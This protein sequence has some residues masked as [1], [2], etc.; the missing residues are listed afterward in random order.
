MLGIVIAVTAPGMARA[1]DYLLPDGP[2][3]TVV[4]G[5]CESCHGIETVSKH[6]RSPKQWDDVVQQMIQRGVAVS[7]EQKQLMLVYLKTHYGQDQDYVPQPLPFSGHGPGLALALEAA[8]TS[9]ETCKARGLK[10][11]TLVVDSI[12]NTVVLLSG[13]GTQPINAA[14][15]ARKAAVVLKFRE[16]SGV[17][18][19]RLNDNPTL[20]SEIK[21]DPT[22]GE[23][24]QGG[25]P[26]TAHGE[27]LGA[28]AVSGA[29]GPADTD[30][31]CAK[32]GLDKV[33]ARLK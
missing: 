21:H 24:L 18:M 26:I 29:Y 32:A 20:V 33:A 22:I 31:I 28:I 13:D 10:S 3:K 27:L 15:A 6:K 19:K 25:L 12:G 4:T 11:T 16:P 7:D 8:M 2:G 1:Q 30:E 17:V 9:Q 14:M 5:A 23:V